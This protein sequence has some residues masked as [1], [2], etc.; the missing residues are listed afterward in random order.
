[1][2]CRRNDPIERGSVGDDQG[3]TLWDAVTPLLPEVD[4][5]VDSDAEVWAKAAT[6]SGLPITSTDAMALF[7][8][9]LIRNLVEGALACHRDGY[10]ASAHVGVLSAV[11]ILGRCRPGSHKDVTRRLQCGL[12]FLAED[13]AV[14]VRVD[15]YSFNVQDCIDLRN[16]TVHGDKPHPRPISLHPRFVPALKDQIADGLDR[17]WRD[18]ADDSNARDAL[19]AARLVPIFVNSRDPI[20]IRDVYPMARRAE[21]GRMHE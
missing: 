21:V 4:H 19:A 1:L 18:L 12:R 9:G 8:V 17:F 2:C 3:R 14:V 11:E 6:A 20:F 7:A 13:H 5:F 16:F 10:H 15:G